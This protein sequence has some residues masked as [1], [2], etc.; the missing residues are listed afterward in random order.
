MPWL[1]SVIHLCLHLYNLP[2]LF[3]D[4]FLNGVCY[5]LNRF[6]QTVNAHDD[7]AGGDIAG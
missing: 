3:S 2:I 5:P 4:S 1:W 6:T 7:I